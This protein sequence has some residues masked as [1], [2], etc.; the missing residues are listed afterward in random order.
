M[1]GARAEPGSVALFPGGTG[2]P[3]TSAVRLDSLNCNSPACLRAIAVL[4]FCFPFLPVPIP[5]LRPIALLEFSRAN[6]VNLGG[7][8]LAPAEGLFPIFW[9]ISPIR[10]VLPYCTMPEQHN[11]EYKQSWHDDY[12]KWVGGFANAQGGTIFIGVDDRGN[13]V[14]V[15]DFKNLMDL[16]PQ[17]IKDLLGILVEVN[18]HEK[19]GK[20]YI[21]IITPPYSIAISLRGRYYYR[22]GSTKMELTGH[23]LTEFLLRKSGK[24]WDDVLEPA[25]TL[26]DIDGESVQIFLK[27]AG[28]AGRLPD[29]SG[30]SVAELLEK[31]RLSDNGRLKRAAILLFGRDPGRFYPNIQ[32]KMGRF[33]QG[34]ADLRFQETAEGNLIRLLGEVSGQLNQKFLTKAIEFEG[35]QRVEKGEYPVAAIREMLLNALVHR[36]YLGSMVQIRVYDDR[37]S[38]WNEGTLPEGLSLEALRRQHPSR[39]RNPVIAEVCFK[40]GYID[41]WG[42]G[43]LK[44]LE[45]CREAALP[46][47]EMREQ[48]GGFM[49]TLSKNQLAEEH[50]RRR[51]LSDRQLAAVSFAV[52][53]GFIDN[54]RYQK[55]NGIGKTTATEEL[56]Q[57]VEKGILVQ[58]GKGRGSKYLLAK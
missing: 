39:P 55:I 10:N 38:M 54:A 32:V 51:G 58:T 6:S 3:S 53:H 23:S 17:K 20:H 50:L 4:P 29:V 11:I 35:L 12:L 16:I 28:R 27:D 26:E 41:S 25:A 47:P 2:P 14:H 5:K 31:L 18:L 24:T 45:A 9:V 49:I 44:I 37:F 34:D 33:G 13:V 42:R 7:C 19:E 46:E 36:S 56:R 21:E 1:P 30:L 48:D 43:T 40:G 57:L 15:P 52:E 8:L 22:S